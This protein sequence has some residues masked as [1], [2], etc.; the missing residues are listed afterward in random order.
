MDGGIAVLQQGVSTIAYRILSTLLMVMAAA[1]PLVVWSLMDSHNDA[2]Y[3]TRT[4]HLAERAADLKMEEL[5]Y[6]LVKQ[7]SENLQTEIQRISISQAQI[8]NDITRMARR[9]TEEK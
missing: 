7:S 1:A 3:M 2:R 6:Q 8:S 5:K 4:E 9:N